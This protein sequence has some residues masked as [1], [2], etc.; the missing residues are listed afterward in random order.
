MNRKKTLKSAVVYLLFTV[1]CVIAFLLQSIIIPATGLGIP[2]YI[3]MPL[4]IC[5]SLYEFETKGLIFGIGT[6]VLFDLTSGAPD[7]VYTLFFALI[8]WIAGLLSRRY[9]R[10]TMRTAMLLSSAATLLLCIYSFAT[11]CISSGF[12]GSA[13]LIIKGLYLPAFVATMI[14]VP[15]IFL[16]SKQIE[17][18]KNETY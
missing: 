10:N 3:L 18:I 15:V 12:S 1:L 9:L 6:G 8:A 14:I 5:I 2:V 17:K 11:N 7:G 16:L 13:M 4:T